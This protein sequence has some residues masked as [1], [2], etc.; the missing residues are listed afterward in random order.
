LAK[1]GPRADI[2]LLALGF[3]I[4]LTLNIQIDRPF[5]GLNVSQAAME[6]VRRMMSP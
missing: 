4:I 3:S 6:N 2:V 5:E 1:P